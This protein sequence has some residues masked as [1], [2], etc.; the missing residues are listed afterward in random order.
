M[1]TSGSGVAIYRRGNPDPIFT[2][3][4]YVGLATVFQAEVYAIQL[5]CEEAITYPD[6]R[7]TILSDRQAA[8]LAINHSTYKS[9]TVN[10]A[11]LALNKV[12]RTKLVHL[13]WVKGHSTSAVNDRADTM[14]KAGARM[15]LMGPEP[16][17]PLPTV[18][19]KALAAEVTLQRWTKEWS[20]YAPCRQ[21]RLFFPARDPSRSREILNNTRKDTGLLIRYITGHNFLMYHRSVINHDL[22][23]LCRLCM[24]APEDGN[25]IIRLCRALAGLRQSYMNEL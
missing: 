13:K 18:Q 2:Q 23:P 16:Y 22:D 3:S 15:P 25:H 10:A 14:A 5:A 20:N 1:T 8:I 4:A 6:V 17:L 21:T 12:G 11:A 19:I 24:E 7:V 9:C